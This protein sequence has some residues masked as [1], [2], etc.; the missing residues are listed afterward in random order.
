MNIPYLFK[1]MHTAIQPSSCIATVS[2]SLIARTLENPSCLRVVN[3]NNDQKS[4]AWW[5]DTKHPRY[6]SDCELKSHLP[7]PTAIPH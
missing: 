4:P 2:A 1:K 6:E 3:C 5:Y 7:L